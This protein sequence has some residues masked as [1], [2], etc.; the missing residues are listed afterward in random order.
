M[1]FNESHLKI[2][3]KVNEELCQTWHKVRDEE[4]AYD[5][6]EIDDEVNEEFV[7]K[8][9]MKWVCSESFLTSTPTI[10]M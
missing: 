2:D 1:S 10:N 4:D 7:T 8:S 6:D 3:S 5:N 9:M